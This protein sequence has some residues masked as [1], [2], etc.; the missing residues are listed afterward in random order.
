MPIT[1]AN[2]LPKNVEACH[3]LIAH[4]AAEIRQ[5]QARVDW[6]ARKLFGRS[7]KRLAG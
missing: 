6:L 5:L 2:P 7:S 3:E 1:P 4:L